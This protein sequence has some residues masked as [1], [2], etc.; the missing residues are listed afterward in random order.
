[1][2]DCVE[3]DDHEEW[4]RAIEDATGTTSAFYATILRRFRL[5][6]DGIH[7]VDHWLRVYS[8]GLRLCAATG[9]D[10]DVIRWFALLHDSCRNSNGADVDH[11]PRAA[12]F[13]WEHRRDIDLAREEFDLLLSAVSCHTMGCSSLAD[14]TIQTCLDADRLDLVRIGVNPSAAKLSTDAAKTEV[15]ESGS[16]YRSAAFP[17]RMKCVGCGRS[18][19]AL[20]PGKFRCPCCHFVV[21]FDARGRIYLG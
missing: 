10:P 12:S 5:E 3:N 14:M 1:M 18:L 8:N 11:G 9:A 15:M 6:L 4:I 17:A 7:G 19:T 2:R 13:A 20:H 21:E 16:G